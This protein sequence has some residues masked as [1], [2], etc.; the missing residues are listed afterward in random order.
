MVFQRDNNIFIQ[1]LQEF[2]DPI[3][4]PRYLLIRKNPILYFLKQVDYYAIPSVIGLNKKNVLL[5]KEIWKRRIGYCNIIYTR[6]EIGRDML[7]KARVR[8]YSNLQN[9]TKKLN[10]WV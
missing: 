9:K 3:E 5:F 4:N 2:L 10:R 8:A 6:T 7:L 1:S